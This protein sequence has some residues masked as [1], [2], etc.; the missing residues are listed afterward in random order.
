MASVQSEKP[1]PILAFR[2]PPSNI[3]ITFRVRGVPRSWSEDDLRSFLEDKANSEPE[4]GSLANE[5]HGRTQTATLT[6]QKDSSQLQE[7]L[8]LKRLKIPLQLLPKKPTRSSNLEFD[9]NFD[10]ITTLY[11]PSLQDHRVE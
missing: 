8:A 6:F 3:G 11:A 5:V 2:Q 7:I 1:K 4:I 9:R 10:G